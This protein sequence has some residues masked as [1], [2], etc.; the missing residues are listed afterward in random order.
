MDGGGSTAKRPE[1]TRP[2]ERVRL[3]RGLS[4]KILLLTVLFVM[5]AEVFIYVP[6][7]AN[8]RNVWLADRLGD[9]RIAAR[10][11]QI[12]LDWSLGALSGRQRKAAG[13]RLASVQNGALKAVAFHHPVLPGPGRAGAAGASSS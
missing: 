13:E 9:A 4:T 11:A 6:S 2:S 12:G 5:I 8:F 1:T 3:A 7:I 10:R